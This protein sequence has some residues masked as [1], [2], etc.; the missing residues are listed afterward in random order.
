MPSRSAQSP[1]PELDHAWFAATLDSGAF[2]AAQTLRPPNDH[3]V[4]PSPAPTPAVDH[5]AATVPPQVRWPESMP[6][7]PHLTWS[8]PSDAAPSEQHTRT[9][10]ADL[11]VVGLLGEGGMGR[12]HLARQ[13]SLNREVALK[14]VKPE[15]DR[16]ASRSGLWREALVMARLDHPNVVPV[17]VL[18][19]DRDGRPALVMKRIDGVTWQHLL[20]HPDH[21]NLARM[22]GRDA[23]DNHLE[24]LARVADAVAYAHAHHVLHRDL[25]PDNVLVGS[26]G[27]VYL[28]D[29]GVAL[30]LDQAAGPQ[31]VVGTPCY[32]APEMLDPDGARLGPHTDVFLLGA[33][34]HQLLTGLVRHA[35]RTL[36]EV[37]LAARQAPPF[38]YAA[39]VPLALGQLAQFACAADPTQRLAT[40]EAFL[41]AL[42]DYLRNRGLETVAVG[43]QAQLAQLDRVLATGPG[44]DRETFIR[45]VHRLAAEARFGFEQVFRADPRHTVA[46]RGLQACMQRLIAFETAA[47]HTAAAR[48]LYR[49]LHESAPE[50]AQAIAALEAR[51]AQDASQRAELE[52][53]ARDLDPD[54]GWG[55]R[56]AIL[57]IVVSLSVG[58]FWFARRSDTTNDMRQFTLYALGTTLLMAGLAVAVRRSVK[59]RHNRILLFG[60]PLIAAVVAAHRFV[61]WQ[62]GQTDVAGAL[63]ADAL[64]LG[65]L[66]LAQVNMGWPAQLGGSYAIAVALAMLVW[67]QHALALFVSITVVYPTLFVARG[68]PAQW[69][70]WRQRRSPPTVKPG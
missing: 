49:E 34:L 7:L 70:V 59:T 17:H 37:L 27:E 30:D 4:A 55:V 10:A 64:L 56:T 29:W 8:D 45:N 3:P 26:F 53:M 60:A 62:T 43:A 44:E 16:P 65:G 61:L 25:K 13:R 28:S 33:T 41:G 46:Q 39:E 48:A 19:V 14:T 38:N 47:G 31:P 20:D 24:I 52:Q 50:L 5:D 42:R 67:P 68:M 6:D 2:D 32:L 35:G 57:V 11:T 12:V 54:A 9:P 51:D 63:S 66:G 69:T 58:I 21:P 36:R 22:G 18:G 15:A 23:L 1:T 40:A